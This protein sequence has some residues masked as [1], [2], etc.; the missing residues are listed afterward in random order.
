MQKS[1]L[2][3]ILNSSNQANEHISHKRRIQLKLFTNLKGERVR[4]EA[5]KERSTWSRKVH[6][7]QKP[8][9]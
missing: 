6:I 1:L 4:P 9:M 2:M 3:T 5:A 7:T 8:S